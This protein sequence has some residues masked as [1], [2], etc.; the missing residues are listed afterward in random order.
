ME[1]AVRQRTAEL[2]SERTKVLKEKMRADAASEAKGQFL[3]NMS[4]EI[5]TPLNGVIGLRRALEAMP[6]P[7]EAMEMVRMIRSS[8]DALLRVINDVLD[9]SK[10][11]AGK[12]DLEVAPFHLRHS[13]EDSI[14]LFRA[15]AAEKSLRLGCDLPPE[16]PVWVAGDETRLRQVVLNLISNALKFT[17]SGDVVLSAGVERQD[18]KSYCIAIE[19]RDTGMGIAPDQR[20]HLFSSFVRRMPPS[21]AV[22]AEP[23]WVWRSLNDW[24]S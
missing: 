10:V 9:F 23:A 21:A 17:S 20:P 19:V 6:V 2:E 24:S 11:E 7:A 13:L 8:G 16:L 5:R 4:H 12:L 1:Q 22:M 15:V 18:G 14:G 3:A